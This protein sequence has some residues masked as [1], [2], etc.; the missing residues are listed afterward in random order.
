LIIRIKESKIRTMQLVNELKGET[1]TDI[2]CK[3]CGSSMYSTDHTN[4]EITYHCSS[5]EA[6]FWD[7]DR[8][9]PDQVKAK[10][11][12]DSSREEIFLNRG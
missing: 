5:A 7:F 6:R 9:T 3:F 1:P 11:H 4:Y 2:K 12:W 10:T 8:G